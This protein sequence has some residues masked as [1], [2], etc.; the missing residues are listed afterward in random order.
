MCLPYVSSSLI[1]LFLLAT[2]SG[3]LSSNSPTFSRPYG[4]SSSYY[5]QAI[6]TTT[7]TG[8][9]YTLR[10]T[11]STGL[12]TYGCLYSTYF[13]PNYPSENLLACDDDSG[14]S[15]QFLINYY[16]S[17][18]QIYILVVTTYAPLATGSYAILATGPGYVTMT[19]FMPSTFTT[20]PFTSTPTRKHNEIFSGF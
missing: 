2:F 7:Y 19:A 20:T 17:S 9:T 6:Q 8:G 15:A 18:A 12:D 14:G 11:S 4:G 16:L 5:Y 10:S 1:L 13:D 3:T